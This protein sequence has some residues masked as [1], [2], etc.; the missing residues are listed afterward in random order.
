MKLLGHVEV[1]LLKGWQ[2]LYDDGMFYA[3]L[4]DTRKPIRN[5]VDKEV[6]ALTLDGLIDK[7]NGQKT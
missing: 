5:R 3:I 2:L 1:V 4:L 7:I 6:H